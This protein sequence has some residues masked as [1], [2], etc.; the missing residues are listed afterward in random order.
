MVVSPNISSLLEL[1]VS[2]LD[3]HSNLV[4]VRKFDFCT[5]IW[6]FKDYFDK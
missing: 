6:T 1:E 2:K 5:V 3:M 4:R